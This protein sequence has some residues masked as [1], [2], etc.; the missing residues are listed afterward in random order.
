MLG[1][2][3]R[4]ERGRRLLPGRRGD[5]L[6]QPQRLAQRAVHALVAAR[7]QAA[8]VVL[9]QQADEEGALRRPPHQRP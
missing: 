7:R 2:E 4:D 9:A 5:P 6:A 8:Q 1:D 3:E